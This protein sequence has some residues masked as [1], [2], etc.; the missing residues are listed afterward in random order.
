M[1]STCDQETEATAPKTVSLHS[2]LWSLAP[3]TIADLVDSA[4]LS[5]PS[6]PSSSTSSTTTKKNLTTTTTGSHRRDPTRSADTT[7]I[8]SSLAL[9]DCPCCASAFL[10]AWK[11]LTRKGSSLSSVEYDVLSF[12]KPASS[13]F[14]SF[15]GY[16]HRLYWAFLQI[17]CGSLLPA[18]FVW[19]LCAS[20][21]SKRRAMLSGE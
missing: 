6:T 17:L 16:D 2:T 8:A 9:A 7:T 10:S 20:V 4:D 5:A 15:V 18:T 21:M 11:A 13:V 12:S 14:A 1:I 19:S 3:A